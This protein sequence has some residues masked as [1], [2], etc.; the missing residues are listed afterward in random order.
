MIPAVQDFDKFQA[1]STTMEN[2]ETGVF[3]V[4]DYGRINGQP[5]TS[6]KGEK[7][8]IAIFTLPGDEE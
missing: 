3:T 5:L 2:V 7:V 8:G 6:H 4:D 1:L